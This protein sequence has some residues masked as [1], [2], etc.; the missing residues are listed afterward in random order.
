MRL[1]ALDELRLCPTVRGAQNGCAAETHNLGA[2]GS[3]PAAAPFWLLD[4][5]FNQ[6][7]FRCGPSNGA[8]RFLKKCDMSYC[9][10]LIAGFFAWWSFNAAEAEKPF[11]NGSRSPFKR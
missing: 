8:G 2:A 9:L 3:S 6:F 10:A 4:F 7:W 1:R 5:F 11:R